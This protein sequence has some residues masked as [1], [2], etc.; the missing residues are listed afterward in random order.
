MKNKIVVAVDFDGTLADMYDETKTYIPKTTITQKPNKPVVDFLR[1]LDRKKFKIIIYS[2]RWW[3]DYNWVKRWIKKHRI[4]C[5]D[6]ILG[7]FKADV[8]IDDVSVNPEFFDWK[9]KF[10]KLTGGEL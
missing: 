5:D 2:S 4:P 8:Y 3:G 10:K 6:I 1:H 9:I 7:K